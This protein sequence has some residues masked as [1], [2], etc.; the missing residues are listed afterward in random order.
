MQYQMD[1]SRCKE[2]IRVSNKW[3]KE[4]KKMKCIYFICLVV[5]MLHDEKFLNGSK[6]SSWC[7]KKSQNLQQ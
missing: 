6:I 4:N 7:G 3:S 1:A 2:E 5:C